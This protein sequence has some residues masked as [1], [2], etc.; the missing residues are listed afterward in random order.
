MTRNPQSCTSE[1]PDIYATACD[2]AR[3]REHDVQPAAV[4]EIE[5]D[6]MGFPLERVARSE[7]SVARGEYLAVVGTSGVPSDEWLAQMKKYDAEDPGFYVEWLR[8]RRTP[9]AT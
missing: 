8:L 7:H 3:F 1:C 6:R 9:G 5:R 4:K 2:R